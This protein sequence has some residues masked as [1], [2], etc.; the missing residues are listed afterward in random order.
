[1]A[2]PKRKTSKSKR[3]SRRSH[4]KV[5]RVNVVLDK[6]TGEFKRPHHMHEGKYNSRIVIEKKPKKDTDEN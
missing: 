1:M 6:E 2:V 3:N 4:I 5:S